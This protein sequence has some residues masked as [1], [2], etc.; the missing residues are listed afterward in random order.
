MRFLH[1]TLLI[2]WTSLSYATIDTRTANYT[3][4]VNFLS[5]P[6]AGYDLRFAG[7]YQSRTIYSGLLGFG[8]CSD[9]E[10]TV[11]LLP[12]GTLRVS[13][14]GAGMEVIYNTNNFNKK[15]VDSVVKTII[16]ETKKVRKDL[17]AN[18]FVELEKELYTND[19]LREEFAKRLSL[20]AKPA[21]DQ[22]Y[23]AFSRQNESIVFKDG[24][25]KRTLADLTYQLY[26]ENGSLTHMYDRNGNFLKINREKGRITSITDNNGRKITLN[27]DPS[28]KKLT[29]A[30]GPEGF[31]VDFV[32]KGDELRKATRVLPTGKKEEFSFEYDDTHNMTLAKFPDKTFKKLTYNKDKDWVTQFENEKGCTE[33]YD[34]QV[35]PEDPKGH[36]WSSL[37]KKC[38]GEITY[39]AKHEFWQKPRKD[40]NGMFLLRTRSDDNG[41]VTDISYHETFNRPTLILK[42]AYRTEYV[43]YD[44]GMLK[45]KKE[46]FKNQTFE[47]KNACLK[48]S[49]IATEFLSPVE[50][51]RSSKDAKEKDDVASNDP[52]KRTVA[53][54]KAAAKK[55]ALQVIKKIRYSYEYEVPKCLLASAK[56]SEGQVVTM[57]YDNKG[58]VTGMTDPV[59]KK[60]LEIG[61][62][63]RFGKP[64]KLSLH[65][66]SKSDNP[67]KPEQ[68]LGSVLIS[69]STDGDVDKV[70]SPEG[71]QI[72]A[73]IF[74]LFNHY[75]ELIAPAA[76]ETNI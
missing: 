43:Y 15:N 75:V 30:V 23:S 31:R 70:R 26:D 57:G 56:S 65:F 59:S 33:N 44:T 21:S 25:Y 46:P 51:K 3:E 62:E 55:M 8:W 39:Q 9:L 12:E 67:M 68:T 10:T 24:R 18:Y 38:K 27:Y 1:L 50:Q 5:L 45:L 32:I 61:Y 2:L 35:N 42:N 53:A 4:S 76:A 58:R 40:G 47:Y 37:V 49:S 54:Q 6:G 52:A 14:C 17:S 48:V 36:Y 11:T 16:A 34:Y 28:T 73:R 22:V 71:E 74:G 72:A 13:E 19:Y 63:K 60:L 66:Y 69:Y 64:E 29:S 20:K 7:S 41:D